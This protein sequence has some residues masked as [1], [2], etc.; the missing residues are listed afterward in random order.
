LLARHADGAAAWGGTK[1][2]AAIVGA[3]SRAAA[4]SILDGVFF[5]VGVG[6]HTSSALE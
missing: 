4:R 1:R 5:V 2:A 3:T 6:G